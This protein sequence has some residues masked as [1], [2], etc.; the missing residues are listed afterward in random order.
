VD[1]PLDALRDGD[2]PV[3]PDPRFAARLRDQLVDALT[4][5][6]PSD[7]RST[8]MATTTTAVATATPY[9]CVHDAAA[10]LDFYV[11]AFGAVET[12]RLPQP[13]PDTRLGHAEILV[14]GARIMLSDEFPE[15]GVL[16]PRT[17]GGSPFQLHVTFE[18]VDIDAVFA[19][20]EQAGATV[21]RP[22]SDQFYGER[23][24]QIVDPFGHR[25]TLATPTE[26]LTDDEIVR[27]AAAGAPTLA[28][29]VAEV[30]LGARATTG[31]DATVEGTGDLGYFTLGVPDTQRG[32]AFYGAL[33]GWRFEPDDVQPDATYSHIANA[34]PPGGI[35]SGHER[36]VAYFRVA[37][38]QAAVDKV[39]ELGGRAEE[40]S[41]SPSGWSAPCHDDQDQPLHLWQPAEGY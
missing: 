3:A 11:R 41:Q 7:T 31:M 18:G 19:A 21:T 35:Y 24:G 17:L 12:M 30:D 8:L 2:A 5:P 15:I 16:S 6:P 26:Q 36:L 32:K 23:A 4:P 27:R 39:R 37:D 14:G 20:A 29:E 28:E 25:W 34:T 1:D 13:E 22:P 33:F 10:A 9:L 38:I 40:P